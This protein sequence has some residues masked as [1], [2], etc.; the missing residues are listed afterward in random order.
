MASP[1]TKKTRP[2]GFG[3]DFGTTNSVVAVSTRGDPF[4]A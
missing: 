3:I 4:C 2:D 1:R